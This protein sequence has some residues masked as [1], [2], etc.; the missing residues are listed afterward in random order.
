MTDYTKGNPDLIATAKAEIGRVLWNGGSRLV[1]AW[2]NRH[3]P[4]G[5]Q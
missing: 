3:P 2:R 5:A 4:S 1:S